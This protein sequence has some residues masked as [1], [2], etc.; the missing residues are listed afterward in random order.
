MSENKNILYNIYNRPPQPRNK[1]GVVTNSS[2]INSSNSLF[3]NSDFAQSIDISSINKPQQIPVFTGATDEE[4]GLSGLVPAPLAGQNKDYF[5]YGDGSWEYDA[6]HHWLKEWPY[7]S[8]TPTGLGIDGDFNVSGTLSTMNLNVEG[9]AHFWELVI[10][11][12]RATG[13][14]IFISPSSFICDKL[15]RKIQ[16]STSAQPF[17]SLYLYRPDIARCLQGNDIQTLVAQRIYMRNDDGR[18]GISGTSDVGDMVRCKTFNMTTPGEYHD[19]SNKDY[20]TF[21][22]GRGEESYN[23]VTD[24]GEQEVSA[25][26]IDL[27]WYFIAGNGDL[28]PVGSVF[29]PTGYIINN[30]LSFDTYDISVC[31]D[32]SQLTLTGEHNLEVEYPDD[33]ELLE[34]AW[35]VL[36]IRGM[37]VPEDIANCNLLGTSYDPVINLETISGATPYTSPDYHIEKYDS[38]PYYP[39]WSFGYGVF[40]PDAEDNISSMGSLHDTD[41]RNVIMLSASTPIDAELKGPAISQYAGIDIFGLSISRFRITAISYGRNIFKGDFE[42]LAENGQYTNILTVTADQTQNMV[43]DA[44]NGAISYTTQRAD[45]ISTYVYNSYAYALSYTSQ[46]AEQ[47]SSVV[48]DL[49]EN[50]YSE[51]SQLSDRIDLS[52]TKNDMEMVGIHLDG[53]NSTVDIVGSLTVKQN[54]DGNVDTVKVYD[55]NNNLSVEIT[56]DKIPSKSNIGIHDINRTIRIYPSP[57]TTTVSSSSYVGYKDTGAGHT[58]AP[59]RFRWYLGNFNNYAS[60]D[61]LN[62]SAYTTTMSFS[63]SIGILEANSRISIGITSFFNTFECRFSTVGDVGSWKSAVVNSVNYQI[64][65]SN[66]NVYTSGNLPIISTDYESSA[67]TINCSAVRNIPISTTDTYRISFIIN[68]SFSGIYSRKSGNYESFSN[69]WTIYQTTT[70]V[71]VPITITGGPTLPYMNIGSD[72]FY[73]TGTNTNYLYSGENEFEI[74]CNSNKLNINDYGVNIYNNAY[75]YTTISPILELGNYS[76]VYIKRGGNNNVIKLPKASEY[77]YGRILTIIGYLA[78]EIQA[79]GSDYIWLIR[80]PG[81][82]LG[83]SYPEYVNV[84][85]I[86]STSF[87]WGTNRNY[88]NIKNNGVLQLLCLNDGWHCLNN[89]Y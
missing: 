11:K 3:N 59:W 67:F 89:I 10:D 55:E 52:V 63:E 87:G 39:N 23:I 66:N 48:A 54:G 12:V 34:L 7:D 76:L 46:T 26:F 61:N 47:I 2:I 16:Y 21:V 28:I 75:E 29:T 6:P 31:K 62:L 56:P 82:I 24:E 25:N 30:P 74:A 84:P 68:V 35:Y 19:V 60:S 4:D 81:N 40:E 37:A 9:R 45:E 49:E 85:I 51:I 33:E 14:Q 64:L 86:L 88:F 44:Y 57:M 69:Y 32:K 17:T 5:L 77:G 70:S 41:R 27:A 78:L 8:L 83:S 50:T 1:F 15:G 80:D 79:Y 53:V 38:D 22:I 72:G 43:S 36:T 13:G 18:K 42:V 65:T 71:D 73:Y 58:S 20:W